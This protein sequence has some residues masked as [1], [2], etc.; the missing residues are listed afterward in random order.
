MNSKFLIVLGL[1]LVAC[2]EPQKPTKE[3]DTKTDDKVQMTSSEIQRHIESQ[4]SIDGTEKYDIDFY[5]AHLNTD[6]KIDKIITVNLLERAK[7]K[8]IESGKVAKHASVGYMGNYNYFFF[9][10]GESDVITSPIAVPSSPLA[11]LE[12]SFENITSDANKDIQID[13]KIGDSKFRKFFTVS[14]RAPFQICE[15]ELYV[16]I[17]KP[18]HEAYVIK[19]EEGT[20]S[21]G[22][23]ILVYKG[24]TNQI[25]VEDSEDVYSVTPK[26]KATDEL[27]RRWY[28]SP[29]HMKY[30]LKKGEI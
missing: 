28:Y 21:I 1:F 11:K 8:A 16:D 9:V 6:D 25:D 10:D 19:F 24:E 15:T 17:T 30:Y 26:I 29:K 27:I 22:K 13:L 12:V 18:N 5:E 20:H 14:E 2:S 3:T 7:D 4:L 23:N